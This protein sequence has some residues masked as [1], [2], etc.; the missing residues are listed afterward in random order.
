MVMIL[1]CPFL[2]KM[3]L[4]WFLMLLCEGTGHAKK[5]SDEVWIDFCLA[6]ETDLFMNRT[7]SYSLLLCPPS[8]L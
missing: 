5:R 4:M 8:V 2:S 7:H 1:M 6:S 3:H